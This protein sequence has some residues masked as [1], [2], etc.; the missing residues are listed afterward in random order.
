MKIYTWRQDGLWHSCASNSDWGMGNSDE[1]AIGDLVC[2]SSN[3]QFSES[4]QNCITVDDGAILPKIRVEYIL[5]DFARV[6]CYDN[7]NI[8]GCSNLGLQAAIGDMVMNHQSE[9]DLQIKI[10]GEGEVPPCV[11]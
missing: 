2:V 5:E 3:A 1:S 8:N 4:K 6:S 7:A 9:F 11:E 10:L